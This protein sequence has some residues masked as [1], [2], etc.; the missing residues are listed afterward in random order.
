MPNSITPIQPAPQTPAPGNPYQWLADKVNPLNML[1]GS[2]GID[3]KMQAIFGQVQD[4]LAQGQGA[5]RLNAGASELAP[6]RVNPNRGYLAME[7]GGMVM[8]GLMGSFMQPSEGITPDMDL[9]SI[10]TKS[11][12]ILGS[13]PNGGRVLGRK[14]GYQIVEFDKG[15]GTF[16][17]KMIGNMNMEDDDDF[18]ISDFGG[19]GKA[20][21]QQ[22]R[23]ERRERRAERREARGGRSFFG[24]LWRSALDAPLSVIG[25]GNL[26]QDT[27]TDSSGFGNV[28]SG[29]GNV[30]TTA[31]SAVNPGLGALASGAQGLLGGAGSGQAMSGGGGQNL[32]PEMQ[33]FFQ[34][35]VMPMTSFQTPMFQQMGIPTVFQEGGAVNMPNL[36]PIQTE[37]VGKISEMLIHLDGSVTKVNA[38]KRHSQMDDDE[39]TDVVPEG[40]YVASADKGIRVSFKEA[41]EIVMGLKMKPYTE[42]KAGVPPEEIKFSKLWT[43]KKDMTPA[44]LAKR[45]ADI[46]TTI[47]LEDNMDVI[48]ELTNQANIESR[49]PW[50]Q[51]II[52]FNEGMREDDDEEMEEEDENEEFKRGGKV[53]MKPQKLPDGGPTD[54]LGVAASALPFLSSLFGGAKNSGINPLA[55]N[56]ITGSIPLYTAG[57]QENIRSQ[58][59]A[60]G[61]AINA[62]ETLQS[63]LL[64]SAAAQGA[65]TGAG[66]LA[67]ETEMPRYDFQSARSRLQ[68]FN[69]QTPR[70]FVD[71]LSTPRYDLNSLARDLGPRG[72][73]TLAAN[74]TGNEVESRNRAL[75]DQFNANRNLDYQR[76]LGLN[77]TDILEQQGNIPLIQDEIRARNAQKRG[78]YGAASGTLANMSNIRSQ[79][80]PILTGLDLQKSQLAGQVGMGT[81][82]Q[83][84]NA[85]SILGSF[86]QS[87]P[88]QGGGGG[89][90]DFIKNL[91]GGGNQSSYGDFI[92]GDYSGQI[93]GSTG[94]PGGSQ[95]DDETCPCAGM[96]GCWC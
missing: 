10:S 89:F 90:M 12:P 88:G 59:D 80:Y 7:D 52:E 74:L 42:M 5:S 18:E 6:F 17:G 15:D 65:I 81:A 79:M 53:K 68:G 21:R 96:P 63:D 69:T 60:Y 39:I 50:L 49:I 9:E 77:E 67:Q 92:P 73:N 51:Q 84:M 61:R 95:L 37:K 1:L 34:P 64:G 72:F 78:V 25:A 83:L 4:F 13:F 87:Q 8:G 28:L 38:Q 58:Q 27:W 40:T 66:A 70:S 22:R 26:I 14:N 20:R 43:N 23:A 44:E 30:A 33:G 71:A 86:P 55:H 41:D 35:Q 76:N 62:G 24:Q 91:F 11:L 56:L 75:V 85:G 82:N 2:S 47:D 29:I 19:G 45:V 16:L 93:G 36:V 3:P 46:W 94:T 32:S 31:L 54:W 57:L 48:T